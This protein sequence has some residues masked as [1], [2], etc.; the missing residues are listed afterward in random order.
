MLRAAPARRPRP[1][2]LPVRIAIEQVFALGCR[3]S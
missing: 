1:A 3:A 2:G